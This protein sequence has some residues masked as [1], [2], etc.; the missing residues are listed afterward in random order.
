[1]LKPPEFMQQFAHVGADVLV[2][3]DALVLK[4]E[5]ISLGDHTRID[6]FSRLEGGQ[7]LEVGVHVHISSHCGVFGGGRCLIGDYVGIAQGSRIITGSEETG[8]VMSAVAPQEWRSVKTTTIVLDHLSFLAANAVMLPGTSLGIGAV[9]AAGSVV[10]KP[11]PPWEVWAG[12]PARAIGGRD[13]DALRRRGAP[14]DDLDARSLL[15]NAA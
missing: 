9:V 11:V 14:V 13:A 12:V 8:A 5:A 10:T 7:G 1:V 6:D 15:K 2:F 3:A 4:P